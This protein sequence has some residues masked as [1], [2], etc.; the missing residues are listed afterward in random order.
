MKS[1]QHTIEIFIPGTSEV[2]MTENF[3]SLRQAVVFLANQGMCEFKSNGFYHKKVIADLTDKN[4]I[5]YTT[6]QVEIEET[7]ENRT[8]D[9]I[10]DYIRREVQKA[11]KNV[12][13]KVIEIRQNGEARQ[14]EGLNHYMFENVLKCL[15]AKCNVM[16]VGPAGSGKTTCAD[17]A[18]KALGLEFFAMSVGLQT[19]KV[20]FMGYM[21]ANG[22][23]VR[24]L[25]R[26]AY[27]N[28]GVFLID[29]IDA[30]NPG[31]MTIVNA[32]LA[33]GVC[34]FPDKMVPKNPK[35]ICC[36][37][38]NTFGKGAD[39]MYVG[40]N[41]LDAATL[42]RF[43]KM[44]FDYDEVLESKLSTNLDWFKLIVKLRKAAFNK[45]LRVLVS[46]RA[47]FNGCALLEQG[48]TFWE[49]LELTVFNGCSIEEQ[50]ILLTETG[51]TKELLK[52]QTSEG[53]ADTVKKNKII[54]E[55]AAENRLLN[56]EELQQVVETIKEG[57]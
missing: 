36:A 40:R 51:F 12:P 54:D 2:M 50:G 47:T 32:A 11:V 35:F 24:T 5:R 3:K 45:K 20:E 6:D 4:L 25:F 23:Y 52:K 38:A 22:R 26:E 14:L 42:D 46:P 19:S 48:L 49:A 29:E 33:N 9:E 17:R 10:K 28:G 41:Q 7:V 55:A 43:V 27:E 44:D 16:M 30:G 39:R 21:D 8:N 34:A 56:E 57:R 15:A 53:H 37:A 13:P 1:T 18:A 31:I